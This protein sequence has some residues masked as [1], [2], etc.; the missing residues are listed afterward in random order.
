MCI[1]VCMYMCMCV[2]VYNVYV[3]MCVYV[4]MCI[5]VYMCIYVYVYIYICVYVYMC[6]CILLFLSD[7]GPMLKTLDYTTRVGS[8]PTLYLYSAHA[9]V[10]AAHYVYMHMV[11]ATCLYILTPC[12]TVRSPR[13]PLT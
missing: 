7:E 6:I 4:Y 8:T 13:P 9:A 5:C 2:Y 12:P 3:C 1:Y 11:L 10:E